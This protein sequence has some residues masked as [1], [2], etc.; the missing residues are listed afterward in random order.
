MWVV[1]VFLATVVILVSGEKNIKKRRQ[2]PQNKEE[3]QSK[4]TAVSCASYSHS[5]SGSD[6]WGYESRRMDLYMA[7]SSSFTYSLF[8]FRVQQRRFA[9][10]MD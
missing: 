7:E 9:I 4:N 8:L 10:D 5:F 1:F 2:M 3:A 6:P